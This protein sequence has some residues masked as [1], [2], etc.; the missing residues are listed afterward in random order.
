M[1]NLP[2][3]SYTVLKDATGWQIN[4][5]GKNY[6]PYKTQSAALRDAIDTAHKA[7]E[8]GRPARVV[9]YDGTSFHVEW[10]HGKDAYPP[11]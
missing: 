6:G 11:K 4:L 1:S 9:M 2:A 8:Q 7:G 3:V 10:V 5:D